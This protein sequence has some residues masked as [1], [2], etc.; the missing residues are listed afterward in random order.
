MSNADDCHRAHRS[1]LKD[2]KGAGAESLPWVTSGGPGKRGLAS[3]FP[4]TPDVTT[5]GALGSEG[6]KTD[7]NGTMPK[8]WQLLVGQSDNNAKE[9]TAKEGDNKHEQIGRCEGT[10]LLLALNTIKL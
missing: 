10:D 1:L 9:P 5:A 4:A 3:G 7:I 2:A 8:S 6:P